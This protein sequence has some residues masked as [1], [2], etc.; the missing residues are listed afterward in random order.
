MLRNYL[1]LSWKILWRRKFFT[2]VSLFGISLTLAVLTVTAALLDHA[3]GSA[4]P[5]IHSHRTLGINTLELSSEKTEYRAGVG[6]TLLDRHVRT[7]P[8]VEAVTLAAEGKPTITYSGNERIPLSLKRTDGNFWRVLKFRFLEGEPFTEYDNTEANPV[9]VIS[10]DLRRRV[11]GDGQAL[12][13]P[14][15][16][17]GQA[18]RVVGVVADVS[19]LRRFAA[20]DMWVPLTTANSDSWRHGLMGNFSALILAHRAQ[21]LPRIRADFQSAL[22]TVDLTQESEPF[23]EIR[24]AAESRFETAARLI[25]GSGFEPGA[26]RNLRLG[27]A[28]AALLFMALPSLNMINL[29]VSRILERAPEIG[30]RKSFGASSRALVGQFMVENLLLTFIG[31]AFGLALTWALATLISGSEAL[32]Y[33]E[34]SLNPRVFLWGLALALVFALLSGVYP[35]WKMS[36][37]QP[38]EALREAS[39]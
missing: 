5:E 39:R 17:D 37:L 7:L 31:A 2:F 21:D 1:L 27:L 28:I 10:Q 26:S 8:D 15:E 32:G 4:E 19:R 25:M 6:Y 13:R 35:A 30:V 24:S 18:F 16:V 12:G 29:N 38:M 3:F 20:A 11:F 36:Q 33:A 9:A 23:T 22:K 34:L 14:L